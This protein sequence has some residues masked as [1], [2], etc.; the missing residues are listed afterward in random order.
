MTLQLKYL[1]DDLV[2]MQSEEKLLQK[3]I[4]SIKLEN[5]I[6]LKRIYIKENCME[7]FGKIYPNKGCRSKQDFRKKTFQTLII[8]DVTCNLNTTKI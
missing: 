5:V 7:D 2:I 6:N 1:T 8:W 4:N 3:Q